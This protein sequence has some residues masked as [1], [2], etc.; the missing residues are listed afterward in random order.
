[1]GT[2]QQQ[3]NRR[4][5]L[6]PLPPCPQAHTHAL[7]H[8]TLPCSQDDFAC[9]PPIRPVY[10]LSPHYTAMRGAAALSHFQIYK[11]ASD[12]GGEG[13]KY[14]SEPSFSPRYCKSDHICIVNKAFASL[15]NNTKTKVG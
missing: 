6:P 8:I 14:E 9:L 5:C 12:R 4:K 2:L 15:G 10:F 7:V 13:E 1:M 3:K 11:A